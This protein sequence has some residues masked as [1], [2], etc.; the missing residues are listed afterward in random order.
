MISLK[1]N[2]SGQGNVT[3]Q[4]SMPGEISEAGCWVCVHTGYLYIGNTL[5]DLLVVIATEWKCD[6]HLA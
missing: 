2:V 4:Y 6:K 5:E 3:V 1:A